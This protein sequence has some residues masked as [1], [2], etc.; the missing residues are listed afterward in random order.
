MIIS[1]FLVQHVS[2]FDFKRSVEEKM[3]AKKN[4]DNFKTLH[5]LL[6]RNFYIFGKIPN[7]D[8]LYY[9]LKKVLKD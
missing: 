2:N 8:F 3:G 6:S 7:L 5:F 4:L 1:M 9:G